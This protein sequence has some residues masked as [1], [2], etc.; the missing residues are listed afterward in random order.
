MFPFVFCFFFVR[1]SV[2]PTDKDK[3]NKAKQQK[4]NGKAT[5]HEDSGAVKYAILI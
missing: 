5:E 1:K 4:E 3:A 2:M